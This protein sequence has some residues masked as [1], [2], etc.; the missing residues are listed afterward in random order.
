[1]LGLS[2]RD[3]WR[4]L[5]AGL[6]SVV[7]VTT[8]S[9]Q[10]S[11]PYDPLAPQG[12]TPPEPRDLVVRDDGRKRDIPVLVYLPSG[13]SAAPVVLFSHGL[14]GARTGSAFLG[15]HWAARG[16]V[17]VF[18]QHK[19]SDESVWKDVAPLRRLAVMRRAANAENYLLRA[20][21]VKV[22][23][24]GLTRWNLDA[25]HPL[26][27]RL[28]MTRVGMSGHSFGGVTTQAVSGQSSNVPS[29]RLTDARIKAAIV[30]SPTVPA[31]GNPQTAFGKVAIPWLLMTGTRDE[32]LIGGATVESRLQVFP[33]LP[34]GNKYE[35][36]LFDGQHSAFTDRD[37]PGDK[38]E[39]NPNHHRVI[40]ALST[41]FWDAFLR[42][43][44]AARTWLDG[45]GA[46]GVL[47]AKDRL[48]KK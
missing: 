8:G 45:A 19:G 10:R 40:M 9:A 28:D 12:A 20:Q 22:V 33:A 14:G 41:A 17:A 5:V 16:Y 48:L 2:E 34:P 39:R 35:L 4:V 38:V 26:R 31:A 43:D 44:P 3:R 7:A 6:L 46:L 27:G 25:A 30:M 15:K 1:M 24:D 21:D 23:L 37:L 42:E 36:V 11:Q 13:Q 32:S 47:E 29:L 18:L